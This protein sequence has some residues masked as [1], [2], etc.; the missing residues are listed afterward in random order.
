M[1][2]G[3]IFYGPFSDSVGRKPAIYAGLVIFMIGSILSLTAQNFSIM[4][5]GRFVQG[6]GV[7]GPRSVALALIRDLY[8]GR[9]MARV[10]SFVMTIFILVP[11]IAP[12]LGHQPDRPRLYNCLWSYCGSVPSLSWHCATNISRVVWLGS[13]VPA[14]LCGIGR[15]KRCGFFCQCAP[16]NAFWDASIVDNCRLSVIDLFCGW[17]PLWQPQR[18]GHGT[19]WTYCGRRRSSSRIALNPHLCPPWHVNRASL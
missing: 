9:A 4:L 11:V 13:E 8:E 19:T 14:L 18:A 6:L 1:A 2:L 16:C 15:G 7:A 12:S 10:M 3:Q 5:A 17:H